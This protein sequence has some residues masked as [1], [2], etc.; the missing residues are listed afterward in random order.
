[1]PGQRRNFTRLTD[2]E[3]VFSSRGSE[4][5]SESLAYAESGR[6][7]NVL[8]LAEVDVLLAYE[9][10]R[11]SARNWLT[12]LRTWL[13]A[14]PNRGLASGIRK[15]VKRLAMHVDLE[16]KG[17]HDGLTEEEREAARRRAFQRGQNKRSR[18]AERKA[19]KAEVQ[20]RAFHTPGD[21]MPVPPNRLKKSEE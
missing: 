21:P 10:L 20:S 14:H 18:E 2:A 13:L 5:D 11:E 19:Q 16:R 17:V 1:M 6:Q 7:L 4:I 9:K 3:R 8:S 15:S 12:G